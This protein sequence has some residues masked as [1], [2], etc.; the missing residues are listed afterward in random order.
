[1]ENLFWRNHIHLNYWVPNFKL[2][3]CFNAFYQCGSVRMNRIILQAPDNVCSNHNPDNCST[4][5]LTIYEFH[6]IRSVPATQSTSHIK[7]IISLS[8]FRFHLADN[9]MTFASVMC[10]Q[11]CLLRS[12][13]IN[14]FF[15]DQVQE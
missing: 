3:V 11:L 1:M 2:I 15:F 12:L 13:F 8:L 9:K 5:D 7:S 6:M 14:R 4:A 10:D